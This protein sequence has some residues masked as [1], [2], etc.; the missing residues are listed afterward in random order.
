MVVNSGRYALGCA[1]MA[2]SLVDEQA[3]RKAKEPY[4]AVAVK[5]M[6]SAYLR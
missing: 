4:A 2:L 3:T 6:A 5:P 1:C